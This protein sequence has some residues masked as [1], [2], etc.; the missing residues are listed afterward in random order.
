M[1]PDSASIDLTPV[2]PYAYL[3]DIS[4]PF[5]SPMIGTT[6]SHYRIVEKLGGGGMGVVYKAEDTRLDRF[7]ALKCLPDSLA[8]DPL[9]LERFRREARA[10]S[11]LN[12]PNICTVYDVGEENGRAF[13]AMEFLEGT[14][15]KNLIAQG[16]FPLERLVA[17]GVDIANGLAVAHA[18]GIVHRDIKPGNIFVTSLGTAKILDFGL[19]KIS[20]PAARTVGDYA[21]QTISEVDHAHLTSPGSALGTIAYMSP[22]QVRAQ[23]LDSRTDLFSFGIVLYQMATGRL[24]FRGD[25]SAVIFDGIMNR[26]PVDPVRLNPDL[27]AKFEDIIHKALEKNRDLRYQ[28]ASDIRADL[29]RL[30]RDHTSSHLRYPAVIQTPEKSPSRHSRKPL[31]AA[32]ALLTLCA[33]AG[34]WYLRRPLPPP[35]VASY[36]QLTHDGKTKVLRGT[37]GVRLYFNRFKP[38][39]I[40]QTTVSGGDTA[41]VPIAIP[42]PYLLDLSPDKSTFLLQSV[43]SDTQY[44]APLWTVSILGGEPHHLVDS[45]SSAAWSADGRSVVYSNLAGE[46]SVISSEGGQPQVL[47]KVGGEPNWLSWSPDGKTIRFMSSQDERL[48]E[49]SSTGTGLHE[50]LQGWHPGTRLWCGR[51][52][53]DGHFYAFLANDQIWVLDERQSFL[54]NR[55]SQPIPL[56]N[57]PISWGAPVFSRDGKTIYGRGYTRKGELILYDVHTHQFQPYLSGLS[58]EKIVASPDGK[59]MA[60]ISFPDVA[61]WKANL[62]GSGQIQL[63]KGLQQA[64]TPRWSPDGKQ[65]VF[66]S[67]SGD[68]RWVSYI[69]SAD[70][71]GLR[72]L[73]PGGSGAQTNPDWS[74]D[75]RKIVFADTLPDDPNGSI[76]ILDLASGQ[77]TGLPGSEGSSYPLWSPDGGS[78]AAI[79]SASRKLRIFDLKTQKWSD[80]S[81][82]SVEFPAWSHDG[83]SI[84]FLSE[85][86][87]PSVQRLVLPAGRVERVTDLTGVHYTGNSGSWMGLDPS[88][89]PLL[90]RDLNT[91]DIYALTLEEK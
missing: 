43:I 90:L 61:L 19:A 74:P 21:F 72:P 4:A 69:V 47:A 24:P 17:L 85:T 32:M 30:H 45:A 44:A 68:D 67:L 9:A 39:S 76:H 40:A 51:W 46:I 64:S 57:G 73:L 56:T 62:D 33:A 38:N 36:T 6:I 66:A 79:S 84:Y 53:P 23:P 65:I 22:E 49:I 20:V 87:H 2:S 58:A 27:P 80:P 78:I 59:T 41:I 86:E 8:D 77:V 28:T 82:G 18:R 55:T 50:L 52:S 5:G 70:G 26:A 25:S 3:S 16:A 75:G 37:D 14:T 15:L 71:S 91:D 42:K 1:Y 31:I 89:A 13:I 81:L 88:D 60:Y 10:A 7:V 29:E 48:W 63:S 35:R 11:A 54:R 83:H 34:F 12:H